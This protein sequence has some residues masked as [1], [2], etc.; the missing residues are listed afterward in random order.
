VATSGDRVKK[1]GTDTADKNIT[2]QWEKEILLQLRRWL[3]K[4]Q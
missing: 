1:L 4:E 2:E 3:Q